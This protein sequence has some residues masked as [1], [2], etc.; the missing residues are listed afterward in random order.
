MPIPFVPYQK[1][2]QEQIK[3]LAALLQGELHPLEDVALQAPS[4]FPRLTGTFRQRGVEIRVIQ[5]VTRAGSGPLSTDKYLLVSTR[6]SCTLAMKIGPKS[7]LRKLGR[8]IWWRHIST[9]NK[10]LDSSYDITSPERLRSQRFLSHKKIQNLLL[11]LGP[12]H[13]LQLAER[14]L[15]LR[16][17]ITSHQVFMA[18]I[19]AGH[20]QRLDRLARLCENLT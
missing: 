9:G 6:C 12:F 14:R 13:T 8:L 4:P 15:C 17:L 5:E 11:Q 20:L 19:L 16:Y 10:S 1:E 2:Y 7:W 3:I 18:R